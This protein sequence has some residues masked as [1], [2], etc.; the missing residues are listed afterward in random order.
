MIKTGKLISKKSWDINH[1]LKL[2]KKI[3]EHYNIKTIWIGIKQDLKR[4]PH[5][6]EEL[7]KFES[8]IG[9][10]DLW[11]ILFLL[12]NTDLLFCNPTG[13]FHLATILKTK[14]LSF[15]DEQ[16]TLWQNYL[17]NHLHTIINFTSVNKIFKQI[18]KTILK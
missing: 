2:S 3:Y 5:N 8:L 11:S 12:K 1:S 13:V 10:T 7:F 16:K 18:N 14:S 6:A 4:L 15:A 9:K 17:N